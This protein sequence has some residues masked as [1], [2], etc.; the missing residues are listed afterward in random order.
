M[1]SYILRESYHYYT[2]CKF[3]R[4]CKLSISIEIYCFTLYPRTDLLNCYFLFFS[5]VYVTSHDGFVKTW[6]TNYT[7][8]DIRGRVPV[9]R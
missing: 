6:D 9:H 4:Y 2:S 7:W 8:V 1:R 3:G 5:S